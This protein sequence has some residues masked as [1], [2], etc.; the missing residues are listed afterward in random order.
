MKQKISS[1]KRSQ[2][3]FSEQWNGANWFFLKKNDCPL[4]YLPIK[5]RGKPTASPDASNDTNRSLSL[6][7]S[8]IKEVFAL[9]MA[10]P[11]ENG[12]CRQID[13]MRIMFVNF[14]R[15][16]ILYET[17]HSSPLTSPIHRWPR[18]RLWELR[19]AFSPFPRRSKTFEENIY[20]KRGT[21]RI[22]AQKGKFFLGNTTTTTRASHLDLV[23]HCSLLWNEVRISKR[24]LFPSLGNSWR[25]CTE[26]SA[27]KSG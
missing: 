10:L 4:D 14:L 8:S 13:N 22:K 21:E 20:R 18:G 5:P 26:K 3:F 1:A 25:K 2:E 17:D 9:R 11:G 27:T 12:M 15:E 23:S 16:K 7:K 24:A 6:D 19:P